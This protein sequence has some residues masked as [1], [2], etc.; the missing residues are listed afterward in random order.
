MSEFDFNLV[1]DPQVFEQNRLPAHSDHV[2]YA[3]YREISEVGQTSLR[4]MLNG[5]WFFHYA[6]SFDSLPNDF[7]KEV[8]TVL[9]WQPI[10]VPGHLETQGFGHPHYTSSSQPWDGREDVPPGSIP[11]RV[12]VIGS[13]VTF[14]NR[15][16]EWDN[17]FIC[18]E[19]VLSAFVVYLNGHYVG[20]STDSFTPAEF[21]LT[22]YLR[23]GQN[24]LAVRI[25]KYSSGTHL[26][27]HECWSLSGI[28][29]NV[30]L[31]TKPPVHLD[32]IFVH[33][34]LEQV[35]LQPVLTGQAKLTAQGALQLSLS[36]KR[37]ALVSQCFVSDENGNI[38]FKLD[39]S[40]LD[41]KPWSAE[42]PHLY[43][44]VCQILPSRLA[45]AVKY[46][47]DGANVD[48]ERNLDSI[49]T[50]DDASCEA[51]CIR[52]GFRRFE[53]KDGLMCLN[54][55]R[56]VFYGVNRNEFSAV[57]GRAVSADEIYQD[58]LTMKRNNINAVRTSHYPNSSIF[59]NYCDILGLYVIDETSLDTHASW[60]N[61][62]GVKVDSR[63]VPGDRLEWQDAVIARG[64]AMLERDKNHACV[65][66]W[67]CGNAAFGGRVLQALS[68]YF[69][70]ADPSR[71]VHYDSVAVDPNNQQISDIACRTYIEAE[72]IPRF[73]KQHIDKPLIASA[74]CLSLGQANGGLAEYA[75]LFR[76]LPRFQGGFIQ[77]FKDQ[78]FYIQNKV[79]NYYYAYGG[80]FDDYPNDGHYAGTGITFADGAE[81]SKMSEVK[82]NYQNFEIEPSRKGIKVS[83]Y[84]LFTDA[85][86]FDVAVV[87]QVNGESQGE[88]Q[89]IFHLA[90]GQSKVFPLDLERL[91]PNVAAGQF[92]E[93]TEYLV[94]VSLLQKEKTNWAEA[95]FEVA[96]GQGILYQPKF[97]V[98]LPTQVKEVKLTPDV[99]DSCMLSEQE[100]QSQAL[101]HANTLAQSQ[102]QALQEASFSESLQQEVKL[103]RKFAVNAPDSIALQ[104]GIDP[105]S[106]ATMHKE[107]KL[108]GVTNL[109]RAVAPQA[110]LA[111]NH[112]VAPQATLAGNHT[113]GV[114]LS[115]EQ[116]HSAGESTS[117]ESSHDSEHIMSKLQKANAKKLGSKSI[118][119]ATSSTLVKTPHKASNA[120][121]KMGLNAKHMAV[122]SNTKA[123]MGSHSSLEVMRAQQNLSGKEQGTAHFAHNGDVSKKPMAMMRDKKAPL[124]K[125]QDSLHEATQY[126]TVNINSQEPSSQINIIEQSLDQAE[127][128]KRKLQAQRESLAE[129]G[130]KV[131]HEKHASSAIPVLTQA[132]TQAL[133]QVIVSARQSAKHGQLSETQDASVQNIIK[134]IAQEHN[135]GQ[136]GQLTATTPLADGL[137]SE[138]NTADSTLPLEQM[139]MAS[140]LAKAQAKPTEEPPSN[141]LI[142]DAVA[143]TVLQQRAGMGLSESEQRLTQSLIDARIDTRLINGVERG[144]PRAS[145]SAPVIRP[146]ELEFLKTGFTYG[147]NGYN[148]RVL[149]SI[150]AGGL[151]SYQV[152]EQEFMKG[153]LRPNFWRAPTDLER[154]R[155]FPF[156]H[157]IW[158]N[159]GSYA[160]CVE[161]HGS[162]HKDCACIRFKYQLATLPIIAYVTITYSIYTTGQIKVDVDY[163]KAEGLP[164]MPEF[165]VLIPLKND[166]ELL[167]FYARG[168]Q[169]NYPDR[170]QGYPLGYYEG[171]STYEEFELYMRPQECG[172]H[173]DTR[174]F[175]LMDKEQYHGIMFNCYD[176]PFNFSALPWSPF[177]IEEALHPYELSEE[178]EQTFVKISSQTRGVG[179][180]FNSGQ[181]SSTNWI[182]P[183]EDH[184]LTFV[185]SGF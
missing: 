177:M 87:L 166:F 172:N 146:S 184:H 141:D 133:A 19:G 109:N 69:K 51:C 43:T 173:C 159:A 13:Y 153:V 129:R 22:P 5:K 29:R 83:N 70:K 168:P 30:Y 54:G 95:G 38:D 131:S 151:V 180:D 115:L 88:Y 176:K 123:D 91:D 76:S 124:L 114:N 56:I 72:H 2:C 101:M 23:D 18:F 66:M 132:Q 80:D 179:G 78:A 134:N 58:L 142:K 152:D 149:F 14:F 107:S 48:P 126:D 144:R 31:F 178:V 84:S 148:F 155:N 102:H 34:S 170:K 122:K 118:N 74:C 36:D 6:T 125:K 55:Q 164:D 12:N 42:Y 81:T 40:K 140:K 145:M 10:E 50:L 17:C 154:S 7:E 27:N 108:A 32:D 185:M 16:V 82:F 138:L 89:T 63:T 103:E 136:V 39:V 67:S 73:L 49:L 3:N 46:T 71:L 104:Q 47:N 117:L 147:V 165:G 135:H 183:N 62:E 20:Y 21:D 110:T 158:K 111:G 59:Y 119:V 162:M 98:E 68:H 26:E 99:A 24:R 60:Q 57:S 127:Q 9:E 41:I 175:T 37:G 44:L 167:N 45:E 77:D 92:K 90:P 75:K 96:F 97:Y 128:S 53:L 163:Q 160:K 52:I 150:A 11:L 100:L 35:S 105:K 94:K 116:A 113:V 61:M 85:S 25:F 174:F 121:S 4:T 120:A 143:S 139:Q 181:D 106:Q 1:K 182:V 157:A 161:H 169:P 171:S 64:Q 15:N 93:D 137:A 65:L 28:F 130:T 112:T 79:G 8:F 156:T 33:A 86:E